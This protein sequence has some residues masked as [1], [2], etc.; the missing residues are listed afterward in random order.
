MIICDQQHHLYLTLPGCCLQEFE[1]CTIYE[2]NCG[3]IALEWAVDVFHQGSRGH[4]IAN[5]LQ[6]IVH[7]LELVFISNICLDLRLQI[8]TTRVELASVGQ[9]FFVVSSIESSELEY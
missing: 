6:F 9:Q 3:H 8:S 7:R 4:L 1:R 5:V 2:K